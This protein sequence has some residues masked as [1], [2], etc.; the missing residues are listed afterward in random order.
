METDMHNL[1]KEAEK[2]P[3]RTEMQEARDRDRVQLQ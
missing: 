2:I 1:V 3:A